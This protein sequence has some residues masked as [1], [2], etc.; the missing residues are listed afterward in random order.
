MRIRPDEYCNLYPIANDLKDDEGSLLK[1]RDATDLAAKKVFDSAT[2]PKSTIISELRNPER[3]IRRFAANL[4][5][6]H[7]GHFLNKVKQDQI[8]Y[9]KDLESGSSQPVLPK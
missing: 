1:E 7:E 8:D 9:A 4:V 2:D 6:G 3:M 5:K